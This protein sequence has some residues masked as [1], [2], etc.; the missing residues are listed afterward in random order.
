MVETAVILAA[1]RGS[2]MWPYGDTWP[3]AALPVANRPLI[4][5]QIETLQACGIKTI[6]VVIDHLGAQ[7]RDAIGD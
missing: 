6:V 7:I 1:G 5:W 2:K 3:K 4:Q